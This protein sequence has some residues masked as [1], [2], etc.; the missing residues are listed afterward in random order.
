MGR[1]AVSHWHLAPG[2]VGQQLVDRWVFEGPGGRAELMVEGADQVDL[3]QSPYSP[4]MGVRI[5]RP[6]L[7]VFWNP[8]DGEPCIARWKWQH[9]EAPDRIQLRQ[10]RESSPP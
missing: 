2:W 3:M 4:Q 5:L 10:E 8:V 9:G 7:L 1:K 6:N